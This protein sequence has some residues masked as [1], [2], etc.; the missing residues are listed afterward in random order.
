LHQ[1]GVF[2]FVTAQKQHH[3]S[4]SRAILYNISNEGTVM[5]SFLH[6]VAK[7]IKSNNLLQEGDTVIVGVSGGADS[8]ALLD[9]LHYLKKLRLRIIIAHLDH[10]LRGDDSDADAAFVRNIAAKYDLPFHMQSI[11]VRQYSTRNRLSLEEG[12]RAARHAMFDELSLKYDANA[13]ALGHHADDQAETILMRLLRGAGA[14]GLCG[15]SPKTARKYV[16][17]LLCVSRKEIEDYLNKRHIPFRTDAS[18]T[19]MRFLRNRIRHELIPYLETY[20][21]SVRDRLVAA[22]DILSADEILLES[23]TEVAFRRLASIE[24]PRVDIDLRALRSENRGLRFRLYRKAIHAAKGDLAHITLKHLQ[25][26]DDLALSGKPNS[27]LELPGQ[28]TITR[29]YRTMH[30][31]TRIGGDNNEPFEFII[32]GPGDYPL[33]GKRLLRITMNGPPEDWK[34]ITPNVAFFDLL[35]APFPWIARTFRA[36]DRFTPL[37]MTGTRKIK[38]FFIDMKIPLKLRRHIPLL[39]SND[40]IFWIG[41]LRIA[42]QARITAET[43]DVTAVEILEI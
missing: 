30:I 18:N 27:D 11:D 37:G 43:K 35:K 17:P 26:I 28:L 38:D 32:H 36:G 21:P 39:V 24:D 29:S 19:D 12:G 13:V 15:I 2:S 7:N 5:H 6:K 3:F 23:V 8:I 14:T 1:E 41:G 31:T 22:A 10:M 33:P 9:V 40:T 25:R 42:E 4:T 34:D 20:N 16:R